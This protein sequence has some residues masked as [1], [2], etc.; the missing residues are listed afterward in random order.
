MER[1]NRCYWEW[2]QEEEELEEKQERGVYRIRSHLRIKGTI[3]AANVPKSAM[4]TRVC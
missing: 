1:E 2:K 3:A 4:G